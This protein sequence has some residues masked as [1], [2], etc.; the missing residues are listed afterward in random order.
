MVG[1]PALASFAFDANDKLVQTALLFPD[2]EPALI[3]KL[4]GG[5]HGEPAVGGSQPQWQDEQRGTILTVTAVD[6][7]T[8]L[9]YRPA[10][11]R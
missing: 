10:A 8:V 4:V 7:G 9:L 6:R 1:M 2:A 11:G 5:I 3:A